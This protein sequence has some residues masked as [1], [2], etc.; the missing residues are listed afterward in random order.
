MSCRNHL[1]SEHASKKHVGRG[2]FGR[3]EL[4][5]VVFIVVVVGGLV[6]VLVPRLRERANRLHCENNLRQIG[7]AIHLFRDNANPPSLPS[8]RIADYYATWAVQI[9]PFL[10]GP[11]TEPLQ[12]WD[13]SRP[14]TDQ[15]EAARKAQLTVYACPS[16]R[17]P[18]GLSVSGD[19][20]D[21][22]LPNGR[23]FPGALSDY[24]CAAG[25]GD[26]RFPWTGPEANGTIILG[27]VLEKGPDDIIKRWRS[28]TDLAI[29]E[30]GDKSATVHVGKATGKGGPL[31]K[32]ILERGTSQT[33]LIG[34][35]HVRPEDF[36]KAEQG[37]GSAYNGGRPA[38][39]SR[40][41]GPG[42]G[43]AQSIYDPIDL[44]FPIFGSYHPGICL[45]L[46]ADGSVRPM[47]T[48]VKGELLG[49]MVVRS[50]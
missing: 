25:D 10:G 27:E 48:D 3:V 1:L 24:A 43:L 11:Q 14:Y 21:N 31:Q 30:E 44:K 38:S 17:S 41:A 4:V 12:E 18:P 15:P 40:I 23:H 16:R 33:I 42:H 22:N 19:L 47:R 2:G 26:P 45:F 46:M 9:V 13:L 8:A 39:F 37:D 32:L 35:K 36:G 6:M 7:M 49:R 5:V 29:Q 50:Q 34:E 20:A 28:R